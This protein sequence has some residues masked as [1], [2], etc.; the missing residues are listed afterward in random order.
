MAESEIPEDIRKAAAYWTGMMFAGVT[1]GGNVDR[2]AKVYE[3]AKGF[4]ARAL[5]AERERCARVAED[6][7][8]A[9]CRDHFVMNGPAGIAHR[10]AYAIRQDSPN[11]PTT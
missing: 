11:A 2:A 10:I 8:K 6:T 1:L 5:L 9:Y 7:G 3:E 4:M